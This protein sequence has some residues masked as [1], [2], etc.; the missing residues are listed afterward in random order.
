MFVPR[1]IEMFWDEKLEKN[2]FLGVFALGKV[3]SHFKQFNFK[4]SEDCEFQIVTVS[5]IPKITK[6]ENSYE[7]LHRTSS[8]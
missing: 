3:W 5:I 6:N 7:K 2:S 1:I 8:Y 4:I